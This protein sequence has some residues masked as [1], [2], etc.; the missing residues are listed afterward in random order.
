MSEKCDPMLRR[1]FKW[2]LDWKAKVKVELTFH[3]LFRALKFRSD[4]IQA[5]ALIVPAKHT[6]LSLVLF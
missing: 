1:L 5:Y 3:S 4:E 6:A 2:T